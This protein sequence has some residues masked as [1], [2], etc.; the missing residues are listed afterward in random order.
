MTNSK[1]VNVTAFLPA[2]D[3]ELSS[4]FY[5][6]LGFVA[7]ASITNATR[8]ERDG[9]GFW[10]QNYYVEE[11]AGNCMLCLYVEDV[12]S[13]FAHI[14]E[15]RFEHAYGGTARVLAEPHAQD[16]G[17]MM[18]FADPAGVLWHVRENGGHRE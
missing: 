10:L 9:Y 2:K 5:T 15:M 12:S 13:W 4:R 7:V 1:V 14:K 18:Q 17:V 11:W 3:F 16:N 8:F 6:D